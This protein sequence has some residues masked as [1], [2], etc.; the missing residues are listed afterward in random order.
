V[1]SSM[2]SG[3]EHGGAMPVRV[4]LWQQI[5]LGEGDWEGDE[6][7]LGRGSLNLGLAPSLA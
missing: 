1:V 7:Q 5:Q 6:Q 3:S 2:S 4:W